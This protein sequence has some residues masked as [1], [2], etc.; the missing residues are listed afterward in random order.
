MRTEPKAGRVSGGGE[1][2]EIRQD[3]DILTSALGLQ[4]EWANVNAVAWL[5]VAVAAPCY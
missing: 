4:G 5:W 3:R 1:R 2:R